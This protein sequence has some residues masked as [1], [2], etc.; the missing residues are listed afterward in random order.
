LSWVRTKEQMLKKVNSWAHKS[1]KHWVSL[2]EQ[3][4]EYS[5][6]GRDFVHNYQYN[7]VSNIFNINIHGRQET[8]SP[9]SIL[10]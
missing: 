4:F 7:E 9:N 6:K 2:I 10:A 5:F 3:E 8:T 1:D